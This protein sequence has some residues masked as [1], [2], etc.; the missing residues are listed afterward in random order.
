MKRILMVSTVALMMAAMMVTMALPAFA[1]PSH[2]PQAHGDGGL[3]CP[4]T[5]EDAGTEP[6]AG[7]GGGGTTVNVPAGPNAGSHEVGGSGGGGGSVSTC[8]GGASGGGEDVGGGGGG[9]T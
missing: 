9:G 5:G 3:L 4:T 8:R 7:F 2:P 1:A 6:G